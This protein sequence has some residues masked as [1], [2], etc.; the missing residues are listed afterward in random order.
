[1]ADHMRSA[2]T[3]RARP[4]H[5]AVRQLL[6][7]LIQRQQE[8]WRAPGNE[9]AADALMR[10]AN[11]DGLARLAR[12]LERGRPQ[13]FRR[14][15]ASAFWRKLSFRCR[16]QSRP[17]HAQALEAFRWAARNEIEALC[18]VSVICW[19]AEPATQP[20][21]QIQ[22][23]INERMWALQKERRAYQLMCANGLADQAQVHLTQAAMHLKIAGNIR[24]DADP[25]TCY[26][27]VRSSWTDCLDS[28]ATKS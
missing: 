24:R 22:K 21:Q 13:F 15:A 12:E 28:Q 23:E 27:S 5:Q 16:L 18:A 19:L 10:I 11:G 8:Q 1:M 26:A 7:I 6:A 4:A 2:L 3:R 9:A 14:T 25:D 20:D 17:Q